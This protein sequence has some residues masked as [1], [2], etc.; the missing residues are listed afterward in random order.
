[1]ERVRM[2][3]VRSDLIDRARAGD[4]LALDVL[5][6]ELVDPAYSLAYIL[7]RDREAAEDAVQEAAVRAW[8]KLGSLRPGAEVRPWFLAFVANQCRNARRARWRSVL[9]LEGV[10][11]AVTGDEDRIV[12]GADLR[13]A[14]SGLGYDQRVAVVLHYFL[15]LPLEE[16][17]LITKVPIGTV[18]S[19][20]H[21]ATAQLRA[22][23]GAREVV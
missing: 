17:A 21:R 14:V 18:K 5:F 22:R 3:T 23:L 7:L 20:L 8:R 10:D 6:G 1:M 15:D 12:R 16:V 9:K 2:Q 13:R 11:P 19:R 4:S